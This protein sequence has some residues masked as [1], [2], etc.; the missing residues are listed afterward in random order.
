M[1]NHLSTSTCWLFAYAARI[2]SSARQG[3]LRYL[4]SQSRDLFWLAGAALN[5]YLLVPRIF[6]HFKT[7]TIPYIIDEWMNRMSIKLYHPSSPRSITKLLIMENYFI[8][9]VNFIHQSVP[10]WEVFARLRLRGVVKL[11]RKNLIFAYN[12]VFTHLH[13]VGLVDSSSA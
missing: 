10:T 2:S 5:T 3:I 1:V 7:F 12:N 11:A 6:H 4:P 8:L 13:M 9:L